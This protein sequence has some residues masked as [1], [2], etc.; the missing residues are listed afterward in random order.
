MI[1]GVIDSRALPAV[2]LRDGVRAVVGALAPSL[3]LRM[4]SLELKLHCVMEH[5]INIARA[6]ELMGTV[7]SNDLL[8]G[9]IPKPEQR[10]SLH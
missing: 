3:E 2:S 8:P 10:M 1:V 7:M 6:I 5:T 9:E 4:Q